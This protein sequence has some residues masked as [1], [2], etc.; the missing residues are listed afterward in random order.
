MK[1]FVVWINFMWNCMKYNL[2]VDW[3]GWLKI[4]ELYYIIKFI[5]VGFISFIIINIVL[6]F[7]VE[8]D[9]FNC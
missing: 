8:K 1:D 9:N 3:D 2:L 5:S 4:L 7:F 6:C